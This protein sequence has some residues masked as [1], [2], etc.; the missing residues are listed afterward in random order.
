MS[1]DESSLF[2]R[3]YIFLSQYVQ[4]QEKK[5]NK[6]TEPITVLT[7]KADVFNFLH[8]AVNDLI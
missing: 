7:D 3:Y 5:I 6:F 4:T 2:Q 8:L 1:S